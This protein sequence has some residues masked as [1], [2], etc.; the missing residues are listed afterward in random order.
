MKLLKHKALCFTWSINHLKIDEGCNSIHI[1]RSL[2]TKHFE[3]RSNISSICSSNSEANDSEL[4]EQFWRIVS[5]VLTVDV[6]HRLYGSYHQNLPSRSWPALGNILAFNVFLFI[7]R[8]L[9]YYTDRNIFM[10]TRH[11]LRK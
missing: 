9:Y 7:L 5:S 4:L 2:T 10:L 8:T 3:Y 11:V 6:D 1:I